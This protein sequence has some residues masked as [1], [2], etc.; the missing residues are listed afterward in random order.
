MFLLY[1][2]PET[3]MPDQRYTTRLAAATIL[4]GACVDEPNQPSDDTARPRP[5][6]VAGAAPPVLLAA[7]DLGCARHSAGRAAAKVVE[8]TP[9]TFATLGDNAY[10]DGSSS[11]YRRCYAP[12]WG[13]FLNRTRPAPGNHD[14]HVSGASGYFNYFG[15]RAGPRGRGY[16]SYNLGSWHIVVLNSERNTREQASWLK[17]DLA[18][19]RNRCT[20][21]YWHRSLF[22]SGKHAP[23]SYM[24]PLFALLYSAGAEVVLSAHNH[25]YERFA[26]QTPSGRR[27][28]ARGIRQFVVGTGGGNLYSFRSKKPNSQVRYNSGHGVLKLTLAE[29]SYS[30]RF[31]PVEGKRFYDSGAGKCH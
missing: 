9:G 4:L 30:W 7:G 15:S 26:P 3:D 27:D 11:D 10:P 28:D 22:T 12:T 20:L 24:R 2:K 25:Q 29:G 6:A 1:H 5:T 21:A 23:S 17:A 19:N 16:Y 13:R 8:R 14:Y 18:R 31:L